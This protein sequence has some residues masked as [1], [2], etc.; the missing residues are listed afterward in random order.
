MKKFIICV[1]LL[2][3]LPAFAQP[4]TKNSQFFVDKIEN[5]C[6]PWDGHAIRF[7]FK[8]N[9]V[10]KNMVVISIYKWDDKVPQT[11]FYLSGL[12]SPIGSVTSCHVKDNKNICEDTSGFIT[13]NKPYKAF[14]TGDYVEGEVVITKPRTVTFKF[15]HTIPDTSRTSP[16]FCG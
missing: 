1:L 16:V 15:K 12:I 14:K 11:Q 4:V 10:D 9:S 8:D 6:A 2:S 3:S 13:L 5:S 7:I